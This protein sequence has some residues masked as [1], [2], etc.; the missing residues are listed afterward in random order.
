MKS[1]M[2]MLLLLSIT[3]GV[4]SFIAKQ[5]NDT[6]KASRSIVDAQ[7]EKSTIPPLP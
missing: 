4:S 1:I 3:V 5:L 7:Q 2:I 6:G